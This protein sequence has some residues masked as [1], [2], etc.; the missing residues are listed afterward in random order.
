MTCL[1]QW[2]GFDVPLF[3]GRWAE[4]INPGLSRS[5]QRPEKSGT[6]RL[7][8][9]IIQGPIMFHLLLISAF[10]L[11]ASLDANYGRDFLA[12]EVSSEEDEDASMDSDW[13]HVISDDSDDDDPEN[14]GETD[15]DII[16]DDEENTNE[17]E[18][19]TDEDEDD[20]VNN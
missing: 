16:I 18:G 9:H 4:R 10:M 8:N 2:A 5:A 6:S 11:T 13:D 14:Y 15:E 17:D 3:S 7:A 19:V 1:P 20:E 12:G